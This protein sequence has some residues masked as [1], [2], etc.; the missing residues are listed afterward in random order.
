M[1]PNKNK[2]PIA[3]RIA[4][5]RQKVM[6]AFAY[7][8]TGVWRDN[9]KNWK[10]GFV[11]TISL[12]VRSFLSAD[13]QSQ[14]CALTYR[15]ILAI[16]PALA[17]LVA[18]GR[19]FGLQNLLTDQMFKLFP[20]QHT[21]IA[22]VLKFVDSYLSQASEG[23][24]VGVGIIFLL[25]TLISL[26][27]NVESTFNHIWQVRK[28]RSMWRKVTDY[29]AILLVLPILMICAGGVQVLMST[30][31]KTL[32]P[33]EF[34]GS[35]ISFIID[36]AGV[37]LTWLFFTGAYMLIPNA[38]VKFLNAFVAGVMVGTAFQLLQWLFLSGQLYVAKYNA[39]YGSFSFIPLLLLWMQLVWLATLTGALICYASQNIG[40]FNFSDDIQNISPIYKR[41]VAVAMMA[42][43]TK[44]FEAEKE[45]FT[46]GEIAETYD[47]PINLVTALA[48]QL[49]DVGLINFIES[50]GEL[51][52]HPLQPALDISKITVGEIVKRMQEK[53]SSNFIPNFATRYQSV[54]ATTLSITE[55]MISKGN[56]TLVTKL[57]IDI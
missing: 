37:V 8:Y 21:A 44:R 5:I 29:L 43:I 42:I 25:W 4:T 2:T 11:K 9:N 12:S 27:S 49:R 24:F 47:L 52:E 3:Q 14:A 30:A 15:T 22:A 48:L 13:L 26:L 55:D 10:V 23:I 35:A 36:A 39:I 16:V 7:C 17:L 54:V 32:L 53:G 38:K 56:Q 57:N 34:M 41:Q 40:Q 51:M 46:S 50:K 28:G 31:L 20:S 45:P 6:D 1:T 18:I 33:F 19:G